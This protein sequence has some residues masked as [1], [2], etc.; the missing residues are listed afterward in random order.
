MTIVKSTALESYLDYD[1]SFGVLPYP[2]YDEDQKE[3]GYRSWNYDGNISLPA[4]LRNEQMIAETMELL[5]FYGEPVQIAV[6]EKMLGKQ[7]AD[8]PDD[9]AMLNL[10]W[11][12]LCSDFGTTYSHID[13]SLDTNMYML[14]W[15]TNPNGSDS[16]A[17]YVAGYEK[18]ANKGLETFM[19]KLSKII[20]K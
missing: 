11:N 4:Y 9:A 7:V 12:N 2:M 1:I 8:T 20:N 14:P 13:G 10:I 15:L 16:I 3:I 6:F 5:A 17:S 19:K 18:R